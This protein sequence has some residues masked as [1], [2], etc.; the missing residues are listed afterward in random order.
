MQQIAGLLS[1]KALL[2]AAI[3][4][5]IGCGL[6]GWTLVT[7]ADQ[8]TSTAEAAATEGEQPVDDPFA[9]ELTNEPMSES[10]APLVA[11]VTGAVV[12]P[13]VY[14]LPPGARIKDLVQAAGGLQPEADAEAINLASPLSDA[15]HIHVPSIGEGPPAASASTNM[16]SSTGASGLLDL[17][18]A[19][20]EQFDQLP[21]VG[22]TIASRIVEYRD[23]N[24]P[25]GSAD[26]L[27]QVDGVGPSLIAKI[28][29]LVTAGP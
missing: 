19:T 9:S 11:Y 29:P 12:A 8:T 28:A 16:G 14:Q 15:Q 20:V 10:P 3:A 17:N 22:P 5:L 21:G 7:H 26:D 13:D 6:I 18:S 2:A 24:G 25:F 27:A 4:F 23:V 1:S